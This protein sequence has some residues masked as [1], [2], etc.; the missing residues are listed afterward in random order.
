[1]WEH[2]LRV[3]AVLVPVLFIF[4]F[5]KM[6]Y[7][8]RGFSFI[9][10]VAFFSQPYLTKAWHYLN[11]NYPDWPKYLEVQKYVVNCRPQIIL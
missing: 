3:T 4:V 8:A 9:A 11:E 2:K 6:Q 10:G 5:V 1:M 7:L